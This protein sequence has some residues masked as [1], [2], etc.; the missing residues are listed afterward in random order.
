MIP[1]PIIDD[2]ED[3]SSNPEIDEEDQEDEWDDA[4]DFTADEE[5]EGETTQAIR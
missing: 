2:N 5:Q 3:D 4:E 1:V